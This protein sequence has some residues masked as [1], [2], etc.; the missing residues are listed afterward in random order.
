MKPD[1]NFCLM[2]GVEI[3]G[4]RNK[5]FCSDAHKVAYNRR[6]VTVNDE[7]VTV[8]VTKPLVTV[9]SETV[10]NRGQGVENHGEIQKPE[11]RTNEDE[12]G[13]VYNNLT[14]TDKTFYDRAMRDFKEP[15]YRFS[16]TIRKEK[17]AFCSKEY[18]TS[19]SLNRYCSYEHYATTRSK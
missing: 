14:P 10:T 2:C 16:D 8:T 6:N 9:T 18:K 1:T 11:T 5:K 15:Y 19:L 4:K 17:C 12:W 13:I 3:G 7:N